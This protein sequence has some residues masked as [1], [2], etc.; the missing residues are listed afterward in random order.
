MQPTASPRKFRADVI[1]RAQPRALVL[2]RVPRL[3][4]EGKVGKPMTKRFGVELTVTRLLLQ[5]AS[6]CTRRNQF[7]A[8]EQ[9]LQAVRGY[10]DDLPHPI[11]LLAL[12]RLCQGRLPEAARELEGCLATYP[13]H[14]FG[15]ALL[16]LVYRESGRSGWQQWAHEVIADGSDESAITLARATLGSE[17]P[18]SASAAPPRERGAEPA[19]PH[20]AR[21]YG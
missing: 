1:F 14:Q 6:M 10:R 11:S 17:A 5:V 15:K 3:P 20:S 2:R 7:A 9:I 21:L 18:P 19:V 16:A 4:R 12:T 8:A 13:H